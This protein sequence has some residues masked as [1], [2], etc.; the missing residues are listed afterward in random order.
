[1]LAVH[2]LLVILS[3][4]S[5][6]RA[7]SAPPLLG[8]GTL[9]PEDR[10][11]ATTATVLAHLRHSLE[12]IRSRFVGSAL[13][14]LALYA[15]F[16]LRIRKI[17][18]ILRQRMEERHAERE[19]IARELHDTLMQGIQALLFRLELWTKDME[20]PAARR[21]EIATVVIQ[22]RQIV[23]EGRDRLVELRRPQLQPPDFIESL[24]EI[25]VAESNGQPTRLEVASHGPRRL[26]RPEVYDHL[27]DIAREAIRNAYRHSCAN[28]I[29][30][31]V[32]FRHRSLRLH[33]ADDGCGI[34][35]SIL[36]QR[37]HAGHFGLTG[38]RER[39]AQLGARFR[40]DTNNPAGTL[41]RV[42]VPGSIA[43]E[44]RWPWQRRQPWRELHSI[45]NQ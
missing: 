5:L 45:A 14:L 20:L 25:G 39:A 6:S 3:L 13:L 35:L 41:V 10:A 33:V 44:T 38:M 40:L 28:S 26:L 8:T 19:R 12:S 9:L 31:S 23:L 42:T 32:H 18:K 7:H 16:W 36:Q 2:L 30:V 29:V 34:D 17:K 11:V 1:M 4:P 43:F 37:E 21:A 27:V 22:V 15:A 24:R